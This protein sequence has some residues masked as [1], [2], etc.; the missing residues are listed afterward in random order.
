MNE[1]FW[2]DL[3]FDQGVYDE[4]NLT[5]VAII[6][7]DSKEELTQKYRIALGAKAGDILDQH[8]SSWIVESDIQTMF[9]SGINML[10]VSFDILFSCG[11]SFILQIPMGFW[12]WIPTVAGEPYIQGNQ[13]ANLNRILGYVAARGMY[14]NLDLHALP[15]SQNGEESSGRKFDFV[16]R[17]YF[18]FPAC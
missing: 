14:V 6:S 17:F 3:G 13:I 4:W 16:F 11:C 8:Y 1:D 10:R 18:F 12:M 15:G 2:L 9:E 7:F 5:L